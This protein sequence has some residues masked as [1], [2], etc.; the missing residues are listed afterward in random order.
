MTIRAASRDLQVENMTQQTQ[1]VGSLRFDWAMI[2]V[3]SW[4]VAG[5]YADAWAHNHFRLDNFFTPWHSILYSGLLVV[6]VFLVGTFIRNRMRGHPTRLAM[7]AG[8]EL[9]LLGAILFLFA[10]IGDL[11]WHTL[12]GIERNLSAA[13]SPT[14]IAI[15]I[16]SVLI[17]AGPFRAA[18]HRSQAKVKPNLLSQLPMLLSLTFILAMITVIAQFAHPF[19]VLWPADTQL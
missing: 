9:S 19:V 12:F 18:W 10:G 14:H 3:C 11:I 4:L 2:G 1:V 13:L 8:Y 17:V 7:P 5:I 16:S 15:L 6:T